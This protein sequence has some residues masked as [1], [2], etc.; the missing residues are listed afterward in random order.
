MAEQN[1]RARSIVLEGYGKYIIEFVQ[2][3]ELG[4]HIIPREKTES[5][6]LRQSQEIVSQEP[7]ASE[8]GNQL[9]RVRKPGNQFTKKT[10][11]GTRCEEMRRS[12][13]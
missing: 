9:V 10:T 3:G 5:G 8:S 6:N 4:P 1:L 11:I 13:R 7:P 12:S 2:L